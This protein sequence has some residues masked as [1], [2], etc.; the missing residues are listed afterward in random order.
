MTSKIQS[1]AMKM[2]ER[3]SRVGANSD[4]SKQRSELEMKRV[5]EL[6]VESTRRK[7][8][9]RDGGYLRRGIEKERGGGYGE[10]AH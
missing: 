4:N 6:T 3:V 10:Q 5:V 2:R 8:M 9:D 1:V 7:K